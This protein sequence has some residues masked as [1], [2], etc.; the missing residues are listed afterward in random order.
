M[1]ACVSTG[2][3]GVQKV[4]EALKLELTDGCELLHVGAGNCLVFCRSSKLSYP[5]SHFFSLLICT[6]KYP[7]T[8]N[9]Q[10]QSVRFIKAKGTESIHE[11]LVEFEQKMYLDSLQNVIRNIFRN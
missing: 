3:P 8:Q 9:A 4:L 6:F 11:N 7:C 1:C 5:P 10:L 2:A